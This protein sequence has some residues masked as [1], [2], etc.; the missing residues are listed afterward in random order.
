MEETETLAEPGDGQAPPASPPRFRRTLRLLAFVLLPALFMGLLSIGLIRTQQPKAQQGA[1][2]P[3]FQLSL[4]GGGILSSQ[5]LKGSPLVINFWASWCVPCREEA[6]T[7]EATF[8]RYQ[9]RGVRFLGVDY[10]DAPGDAQSFVKQY[11]ITYP[12]IRDTQGSLAT[13]FG[14]RG[15]PETFFIDR[16]YRFFSIGEGQPQGTRSGTKIL[17]PVP[18]LELVSQIHQLLAYKPTPGEPTVSPLLR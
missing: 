18:E 9:A 8:R 16:Q 2:A 12:S 5:E 11:G 3:D 17:G 14:V 4:L 7:L 13:T 6:P 10:E 15:V 1:P